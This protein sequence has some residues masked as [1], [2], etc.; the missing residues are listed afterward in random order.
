MKRILCAGL[1]LLILLLCGCATA[2]ETV[3]TAPPLPS[4]TAA[5]VPDSVAPSR[6]ET[7]QTPQSEPETL[8]P[9]LLT[10]VEMVLPQDL[11]ATPG[12]PWVIAKVS[13]PRVDLGGDRTCALTLELDGE[14]VG[15]WR[16]LELEEGLEKQVELEFPFDRY[17]SDYTARLT[18]T[19]ERGGQTL[20]E[21]AEIQ[22]NNYPEEL[23]LAMSGDD[24]PY[25][26]DVLRD[27]NLVIVYGRDQEG[28]YTVP[29]KVW[30]CSTGGATPT[31]KYFMGYKREWGKLFGNVWGQ[32][33]IGI[34]GDILFH[35]VPYEYMEKDSLETEEFNKLGTKASMG[36]IR[37][38][39]ADV[40]WL[41]DNCPTGSPIHI[42][43]AG[44]LP[45]GVE[46]P[47]PLLLDP[48]DPRSCWDPTDP[49]PENPWH[50]GTED[51]QTPTGE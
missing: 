7:A 29:V 18:A 44:A 33:P 43:D 4:A 9:D 27:Q 36:C 3:S 31:G 46:R 1:A 40:K 49:D 32:Y 37:L 51:Q 50:V 24:R 22:V 20:T 11:E 6:T 28:A 17:Q 21:E 16:A 25:Q 47:E 14:A 10:G 39:V 45:E 2:N 15:E 38:A 19:L 41:Y 35:S 23:Y 8:P 13:F 42:Y 5:P 34:T 12:C 30:L 26:V 48:E